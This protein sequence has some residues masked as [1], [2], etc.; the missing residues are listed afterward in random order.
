MPFRPQP[1][2]TEIAPPQR[3][4]RAHESH[5][6]GAPT[7]VRRAAFALRPAALAL[8]AAL[9]AGGTLLA[10]GLAAQPAAAQSPAAAAAARSYR[11]AP[12][13]LDQVLN[14][15]A[16]AAGV[17]LSVDAALTKGKTS[18]GLNGRYTVDEGFDRLTQGQGLRVLRGERGVYTLRAAPPQ[19]AATTLPAVEVRGT[20]VENPWGPVD[21]Y[22]A[23]RS[24]T[25]SKTD[26]SLLETP[27]SVSVITKEQVRDQ[28]A[29]TI[30]AALRYTPGVVAEEYGG[31]EIRV[32][33]Y[34][35]R[36][37]S[38]SMP[39]LDGL[40]T[41]GL[42]TLLSN[43]VEPY[44]LER[45]EVLRGP[46]S[47]MY[48]QNIPGGLLSLVSKRPT[49][50]PLH[51]LE[52][53]GGNWDR[54]QVAGDFSGPLNDS[55]TL[56]YRVTGLFRDG[57]TQVHDVDSQ[58]TYIAPSLTWKPDADTSFTLLTHYQHDKEGFGGQ[59]LPAEGTLYGSP[60][61]GRLS[62][63]LFIGE[64]DL[65]RF[66]REEYSVGYAFEHRFNSTWTVRQ[67]LRYSHAN[68]NQAQTVG[69]GVEEGTAL[70]DRMASQ[71]HA[72]ID[73]V[74]VDSQI[75]ADFATGALRHTALAGLE[76]SN[77]HDRWYEKD[78][79]ASPL[80]L[81]NPVYGQP[82]TMPPVDFATDDKVRQLGLYA[83]DQLRWGRWTLTGG[84]RHDWADT[85]S[86]DLLSGTA[87]PQHDEKTTAKGGLVYRFDNGVAPYLSYSE[88]FLPNVG[89]NFSNTPYKPSTGKQ[90]EVGVKYQPAGYNSFMMVS[91]YDLTQRNMLTT[92]P[93]HPNF[94]VQTGEVR[95]KGIEL[96]GTADLTQGWKVVGAYTYMSPKI[97]RNNDGTVG[98][99]PQDVPRHMASLW[100]D[101]T[102]QE[103]PLQGVGLGVGVRYIGS[104]YGDN[105][106]S[107]AI[108]AVTLTD[109]ALHY[110]R[111][112][113][114]FA[115]NATNLFDKEYVG[116]CEGSADACLYGFRRSVMATVAYKW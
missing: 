9:L 1:A 56:L 102:L 26:A 75:Q 34:M 53:Q 107:L 113:W 41:A 30:G 93:D 66:E 23:T 67:N 49:E 114:R 48:G 10:A 27:Q 42:Y 74:T 55:G 80:D 104:R 105:Q 46:S 44:G 33:Q 97:T 21:G 47:V 62:S 5:A 116:S 83:Q 18:A 94:S 16:A 112:N 12:G 14:R 87:T 69:A 38:G 51:E 70:L 71:S 25:A 64:P 45:I 11:I 31:G 100:L 95:V 91:A 8:R 60:I 24:A 84:V 82:Y 109:A 32:D 81:L 101:K 36:G 96:S 88:S 86:K 103:G 110:E 15:Y 115:I 79:E 22:V 2:A 20:A 89:A 99:Q 76:Y 35:L 85:F 28:G 13:T 50:T 3:P 6:A 68:V 77:S 57:G 19:G 52:V 65:N 43:S 73:N 78:G 29:K 108:P 58:R 4:H 39:Y 72:W 92:D 90:Y 63:R 111:R 106:N 98:N 61:Y 17:E 40:S 37:F 59:Y 54:R 7:A